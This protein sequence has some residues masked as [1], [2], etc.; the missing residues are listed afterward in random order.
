MA[1]YCTV[2]ELATLGIRS[3]ALRGISEADQTTAIEAASDEIDGYLGARYVLPLS[4]WESDLRAHCARLAVYQLLA[5]RGVNPA[6]P[7]DEQVQQMRDI[8]ERWLHGI[9]NGSIVPRVTDASSGA[10]A[11]HVSGGVKVTSYTS[12][13]YSTVDGYTGGAFTG[14]RTT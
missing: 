11:G 14:R 2:A 8:A 5:V 3:E 10:A 1:S 4:A 12:R 6:R 13:G 9:S 7:G